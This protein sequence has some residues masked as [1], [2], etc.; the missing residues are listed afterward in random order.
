MIELLL[1]FIGIIAGMLFA[2][3]LIHKVV[4]A[5]YRALLENWKAQS[6]VG[7]RKDALDKSRSVLKG[8]IGEQIAVLLPE[9]PYLPSDARFI[10]SPIDYIIFD[11]YS[12]GKN[13]NL[14]MLDVKKGKP[15][16]EPYEL[17]IKKLGKPELVVGDAVNDEIPAKKLG[18][19][20]LRFGRDIKKLDEVFR[21]V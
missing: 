13:I 6:I 5:R 4:D 12:E 15:N 18:L 11:G 7:I 16:T 21:Y 2:Y 19:R 3:F 10:G 14:I 8:K 9:F 17:V 20:F 1:L